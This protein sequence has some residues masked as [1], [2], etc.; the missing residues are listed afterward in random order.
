[1]IFKVLYIDNNP[2]YRFEPYS[3]DKPD[4]FQKNIDVIRVSDDKDIL[5]TMLAN[6]DISLIVTRGDVKDLRILFP[7]LYSGLPNYIRGKWFNFQVND[8][9]HNHYTKSQ[10]ADIL[11]NFW[12]EYNISNFDFFSI[13][14]PVYH[15]RKDVFERTYNSLVNQTLKDWEWVIIDDSQDLTKTEH[16]RQIANSD[17]RIRYYNLGRSGIIGEVKKNGFSLGRGKYLLELDHD[18][19]LLPNALLNCKNAFDKFP[20]AGFCYS[21][22]A[23]VEINKHNEVVGFRN[24]ARNEHGHP[25]DG[26]WGFGGFGTAKII[27]WDGIDIWT[28]ISPPQNP[29]TTRSILTLPNHFR[30]WTRDVYNKIGGHNSDI[31]VCDDLDIMM[32]TFLETKFVRVNSTDYIQFYEVDGNV[33]TQYSRNG[34]IQRFNHY[35]PKKYDKAIRDRFHELGVYDYTWNEDEGMSLFWWSYPNAKDYP[36]NVNYEYCVD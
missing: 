11:L 34:E 14:T 8:D 24:Y 20:D 21:E 30:C 27:N 31:H 35:I 5:P 32:R 23:E 6:K 18:D 7:S 28:N 16:I 9:I 2:E 13:I 15:T 33:N 26:G 1:M 29:Q 12:V 22:C 17:I 3:E 4:H 36:I 10:V 25:T 19:I